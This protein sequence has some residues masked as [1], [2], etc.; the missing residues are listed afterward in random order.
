MCIPVRQEWC[1]ISNFSRP[2]RSN[3]FTIKLAE[4]GSLSVD[5]LKY[6]VVIQTKSYISHQ[7]TLFKSNS[8]KQ[9]RKSDNL[10]PKSCFWTSKQIWPYTVEPRLFGPRLSGV[11]D[12]FFGLTWG[13]LAPKKIRSMHSTVALYF[14]QQYRELHQRLRSV[15][16]C[17]VI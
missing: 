17:A 10:S 2:L 9:Q 1:N 16:V 4:G 13:A 15:G 6:F 11:L 14:C 7:S 8:E 3:E 5:F 12:F